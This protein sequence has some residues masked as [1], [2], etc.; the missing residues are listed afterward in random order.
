MNYKAF[1]D[2]VPAL[3]VTAPNLALTV[4]AK[5]ALTVLQTHHAFSC[6]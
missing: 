5:T 4:S 3:A 1:P 6:L 2:L